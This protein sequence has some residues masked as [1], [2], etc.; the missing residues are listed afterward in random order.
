[1][2]FNHFRSKFLGHISCFFHF[3]QKRG[4][5]RERDGES[6]I[7]THMYYSTHMEIRGQL[8]EATSPVTVWF[9][10]TE[11]KSPGLHE[12]HIYMLNYHYVLSCL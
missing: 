11:F 8:L 2:G 12:K 3:L 6:S 1:M 4:S 10:V 7:W 9:P 5:E